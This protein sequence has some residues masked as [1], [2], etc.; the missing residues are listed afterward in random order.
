MANT[1]T[2]ASEPSRPNKY[3][4]LIALAGVFS[5]TVTLLLGADS[6]K[7]TVLASVALAFA[8]LSWICYLRY[9]ITVTETR[10][11][12]VPAE[13]QLPDPTP[14][15][16]PPEQPVQASEPDPELMAHLDDLRANVDT[17]LAE[18]TE[19]GKLAKASG[20]K[21]TESHACI[22]GSEAAIRE[23]ASYMKRIDTVFNELGKQSEEIADIVAKIQDIA[24]QTNLLALNAS[25]EAARAGEHGR[26]FAVVADEVRNLSLRANQS[27][28]DIRAIADNLNTT[29][30]DAGEGMDRI[31]KSCNHCLEQSGDALRAMEAIQSGA[32]ARMQVVQGIT[33][34]LQIQK[35]LT[36]RVYADLS[37]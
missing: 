14:E 17:I 4:A 36:S 24:K 33:D 32:V 1:A 34:R 9:P 13:P 22:S 23:L 2:L 6:A 3:F 7:E 29:A 35:D 20:A 31:A 11:V 26:G 30:T 28:E 19:A 37:R 16:L 12:E 5:A 15:S 8:G 27:S 21:V 10:Y 18:M 25:I